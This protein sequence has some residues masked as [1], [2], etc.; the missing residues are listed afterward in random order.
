MPSSTPKHSTR[1][2]WP[3]SVRSGPTAL[4]RCASGIFGA[5]LLVY[6]LDDN[7]VVIQRV[8]H[9]SQDWVDLL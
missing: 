2:A 6:Q 1:P 4:F 7:D 5:H 8:F 3:S 9:Q